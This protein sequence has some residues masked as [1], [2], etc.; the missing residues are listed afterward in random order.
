MFLIKI[1]AL[2]A[3]QPYVIIRKWGSIIYITSVLLLNL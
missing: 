3:E 1:G 2:P